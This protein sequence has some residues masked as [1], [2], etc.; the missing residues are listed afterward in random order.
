MFMHSHNHHR[1]AKSLAPIEGLIKPWFASLAL[2]ACSFVGMNFEANAQTYP[3][4]PIHLVVGYAAGGGTDLVARAISPALSLALGQP[5]IIDNIAGAGG[6]AG[7]N[8]VAKAK[9]DGYT[10]LISSASSVTISPTLNP[11][12]GYKQTD[13]APISQISLA[14]LIIAVNKDLGINSVQD[15][16]KAAKANPGKLNYASSGLGSGPHFAG[17]L[18]EQVTGVKMIHIP[19]RS[20]GPASLSVMAGDTQLTFATTPTVIQ[21][22]RA[23]KLIGLAVT[24]QAASPSVPQLPGMVS[25]GLRDYEIVQ[26]NGMFAPAGTPPAILEKLFTALAA[27]MNTEEVKRV[28]SAE[29]TDVFV[30]ASPSAFA[31]FMKQDNVFWEKLIKER[32]AKAFE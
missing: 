25:A 27:A 32:G 31:A 28:L 3:N 14:P 4:R 15:L 29:G 23:G 1:S 24:T 30:S 17:L 26:W 16:I 19:F 8:A 2:V 11:K 6:S 18:F 20:G 22:I 10:I 7:A 12:L 9:P 5:V 13:F 21:S